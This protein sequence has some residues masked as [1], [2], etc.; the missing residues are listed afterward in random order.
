MLLPMTSLTADDSVYRERLEDPAALYADGSFRADL[1]AGRDV[2]VALQAAIN[3]IA[4][5]GTFGLLYIPS[6]DYVL[7]DTVYVWKGVRIIG[8]G[9][10]RPRFILQSTTPGYAGEQPKYLFHFASNRPEPGEPF[11]DANPGTFYSALS[12]VVITIEPGNPQA[13]GVR[14]HFAQHCFLAH[15]RFE[16]G[17]GLAG[18][19]KV[20]NIFHDLEF[21]GGRYGIMMTKPSPSWPFTLLNS[22]F[23]SQREA[24]I[25]THEGG[26]TIVR[27]TFEDSP[28]AVV[29]RPE[30]SEEL[31]IEASVFA[32]LTEGIV[33]ISEEDNARTQVNLVDVECETVPA[34]AQFRQSGRIVAGKPGRYGIAHF[35]HG[36]HIDGLGQPTAIDTRIAWANPGNGALAVPPDPARALPSNETWVDVT[37]L[38]AIGDAAFDNTT[39][40]QDA[41]DSHDH[42]FFPTGRFRITDTLRLRPESCLVGMSPIT[43]QLVVRDEESAFHPSGSLKAVVES[44][45]GGSA[46][47]QGL[48][49][50]P[51]A[52]NHRA[53]ALKWRAGEHS[54]VRDVRFLGGH[55]TYDTVGEYLPIY[56]SNRSGDSDPARRWD[57]MPTSLWVTDHGGGSFVGLWTPSPFA[58][59]GMVIEDTTTPGWVYQMSS[60]HHVRHEVIVRRAAHW[61]FY[62]LQFEEE[63]WEGRNALPLL[64]EDSHNLTFNNTY[65][66]RVGRTFTPYPEAILV[67][68]STALDFRGVHLYGPSKYMFDATLRDADRGPRVLAREIARLRIPGDVAASP[69]AL[70]FVELAKGFN[71]LESPEVDSAGRL[72]F[73]DARAQKVYRWDPA[74]STLR[75]VLDL[76][77]E[78][79]QL[80]LTPNE[81]HLL[82]L[83]RVGKLYR[84][85]INGTYGELNEIQ[86]TEGPAPTA[87]AVV[88]PASRWR[89]GHDFL[90]AT[91]EA[92]PF[93]FQVGELVIPAEANF[94]NADLRSTYFSTIDLERAYDLKVVAP[95]DTVYIADEFGQKTYRFT[96]DQAGRLRAPELFAQAGEVGTITDAAGRVYVAAGSLFIYAPSGELLDSIEVPERLTG[97]AWGG[98][99]GATLFLFART[100][101]LAVSQAA[102]EEHLALVS[103]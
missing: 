26:L 48:G 68:N 77:I 14:S 25:L 49:I 58:H 19:Q 78:P 86:P 40:L 103:D 39:I 70:P 52:I 101:L 69:L 30:R 46:I 28:W 11:R 59:A 82:I 44:A 18:V 71:H 102:L 17:E 4:E 72:Y 61:H 34:V 81:A 73:V 36:L 89:D 62:A 98:V 76:P 33:L 84:L 55:G 54:V 37:T 13:V 16:I 79:S 63:N 41:I 57:A 99:D 87:A 74:A 64:I 51:G 95:G 43:T 2:T 67:Q 10:T 83:T 93:H 50:D 94:V 5:R 12:N 27:C 92:K 56:N 47:L 96:M 1:V 85:P 31:Y 3:A 32:R 38:G 29:V 60:E 45:P 20:G 9:P 8:Y 21:I 6:G 23:R 88:V 97:M 15:I 42:L 24:A 91:Q 66:Y 22:T 7:S 53:V 35:S 100:R 75:V 90:E 65:L 80:V